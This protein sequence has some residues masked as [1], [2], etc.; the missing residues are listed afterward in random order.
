MRKILEIKP[1]V[2]KLVS[3]RW[4]DWT[5]FTQQWESPKRTQYKIWAI[6]RRYIRIQH[7][8]EEIS[9]LKQGK[10]SDWERGAPLSKMVLKLLIWKNIKANAMNISK[11]GIREFSKKDDLF[12]WYLSC[13]SDRPTK[14]EKFYR[15][16]SVKIWYRQMDSAVTP[17]GSD[18]FRT[19]YLP[20]PHCFMK[21]TGQK[22]TSGLFN[23]DKQRWWK[24]NILKLVT[25]IGREKQRNI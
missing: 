16:K 9:G 20:L 13:L 23:A 6:L 25:E 21:R 4:E 2:R 15:Q 24:I 11:A 18:C 10:K 17:A 7:E 8:K 19:G 5:W 14:I 3:L 22:E 12:S 1:S